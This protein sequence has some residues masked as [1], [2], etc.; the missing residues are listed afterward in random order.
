VNDE[1][2]IQFIIQQILSDYRAGRLKYYL[3]EKSRRYLKQEGIS[4]SKVLKLAIAQLPTSHFYRGPSDHHWLPKFVVYEFI[5]LNHG[6]N[7]YVK[8][9]VGPEYT[10]LESYHPQEKALNVTWFFR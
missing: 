10:Q 8:F 3:H 9:D 4:A 1:S 6:V 2:D 7:L 5:E